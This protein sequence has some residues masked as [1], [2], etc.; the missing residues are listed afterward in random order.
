MFIYADCICYLPYAL[1]DNKLCIMAERVIQVCMD[2]AI[3]I[4]I[5]HTLHITGFVAGTQILHLFVRM[6]YV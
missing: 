2:Q 3:D 1:Y 6:K 4:A 5:K